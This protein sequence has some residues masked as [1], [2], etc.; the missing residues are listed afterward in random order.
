MARKIDRSVDEITAEVLQLEPLARAALARKVIDSLDALTDTEYAQLW[1]EEA[2]TRYA[3]FEAGR[4]EAIDGDIVFE[5]A[6]SR[7]R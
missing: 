5:R 2:E 7:S 1:A 4:T 6:R 3:D